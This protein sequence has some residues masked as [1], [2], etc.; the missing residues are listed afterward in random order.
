[1]G[2]EE[3][4]D[5]IDQEP[6]YREKEGVLYCADCM[7]ILPQ[8]PKKSIDLVLTDP[9][10][11]TPVITAYGRRKEKNYG[12]LSIQRHFFS[13]L[14][15]MLERILKD[16]TVVFIFCDAR[17]YP[18][19]YEVFY[20]WQTGQLLVWDK[21]RIGM[22]SPFRKQYELIYFLSPDCRLHFKNG[23]T[24]S[25]ILRYKPIPSKKRL[26]GSQK[27]LDLVINLIDAFD[28]KLVIDPFFGSGTTAV[29]SK[30]LGRQWIGIE[31]SQKYCD[32]AVRRLKKV[33]FGC[34]LKNEKLKQITLKEL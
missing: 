1:M 3:I 20:D 28:R 19:L 30:K 17:Y 9:P 7:D 14:K 15:Q 34:S 31:I 26:L 24:Y 32:I 10:Y 6:Y 13:R 22:G 23:K 8:I 2:L 4:I 5:S 18:I 25:D 12:D 21:M 33:Q 27:P 11:S 16:Q 29:A